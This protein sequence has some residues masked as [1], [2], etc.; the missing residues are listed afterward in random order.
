MIMVESV[1]KVF[2]CVCIRIGSKEI[3]ILLPKLHIVA[4]EMHT[5][6]PQIHETEVDL[7][8]TQQSKTPISIM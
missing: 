5:L 8:R 4:K 7:L 6:S 3:H 2:W 1:S